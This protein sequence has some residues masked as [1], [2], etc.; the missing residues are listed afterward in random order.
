MDCLICFEEINPVDLWVNDPVQFPCDCRFH[1]HKQCMEKWIEYV[2]VCP[3]CKVPM[4][5]ELSHI[6]AF[7]FLWRTKM[8]ASTL[9]T[10]TMCSISGLLVGKAVSDIMT[11]LTYAKS[12]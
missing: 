12:Q 3:I 7:Q 11:A 9:I 6:R 2:P 8:I 5:I 1:S 4:L 10:I